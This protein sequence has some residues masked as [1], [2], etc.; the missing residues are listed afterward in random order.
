[1]K[2]LESERSKLALPAFYSNHSGTKLSSKPSTLRWPKDK[3]IS[4]KPRSPGR[5]K[6]QPGLTFNA[7][8]LALDFLNS[9]VTSGQNVV[10]LLANGEDLLSWLVQSHLLDHCDAAAIRVNSL[11]GEL[12]EV[13]AQARALREWFRKFVLAHMGRHLTEQALDRLKPLNSVLQRDANYWAIVPTPQRTRKTQGLSGLELRSLRRSTRPN[14]LILIIAQA[15][16]DL[17]CSKDFSLVKA[18]N[19]GTSSLFFF[20]TDHKPATATG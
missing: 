4:G 6:N 20:Y 2:T 12:N 5:S 8:D 16:A 19:R 15:M 17:I 1:M 3:L 9:I 7:G 10:E 13:A 18:R 11:P 14:A